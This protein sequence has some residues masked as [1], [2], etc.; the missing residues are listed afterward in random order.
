MKWKLF[1]I[2]ALATVLSACHSQKPSTVDVSSLQYDFAV[3]EENKAY[4]FSEADGKL[5]KKG[6][7]QLFKSG[8]HIGIQKQGRVY[9]RENSIY[10]G[11]YDSTPDQDNYVFD[12]D[13]SDFEMTVKE[14]GN[15]DIFSMTADDQYLYTTFCNDRITFFK[16]DKDL[17]IIQQKEQSVDGYFPSPSS[18]EVVGNQLYVLV[19]RTKKDVDEDSFSM[20]LWVMTKDFD[21]Q[22]RIPLDSPNGYWNMIAVGDKLYISNWLGD[23]SGNVGDDFDGGQ[24]I[25][26]FD[27]KTKERKKIQLKTTYPT[28]LYH[29]HKNDVLIVEHDI[30]VHPDFV[31]TLVNLKTQQQKTIDFHKE[32]GD[33]TEAFFAQKGDEYYFLFDHTLCRY[34]VQTGKRVTYDL[35][36]YGIDYADALIFK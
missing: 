8:L 23:K 24:N 26:V 6:E 13:K 14:A 20:E 18:M 3:T 25:L 5:E 34:N 11:T 32:M 29:D 31:W 22:E 16:Y 30:D 28:F 4:F 33:A 10:G 2:V 7:K 36:S 12:L 35:S 17:N 27:T 1:P 9:P 21:V 15:G 19:G